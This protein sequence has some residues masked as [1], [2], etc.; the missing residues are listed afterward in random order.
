M[1]VWAPSLPKF[2]S[3]ITAVV[4][5]LIGLSTLEHISSHLLPS[6][7]FE[8]ASTISDPV[9]D[10]VNEENFALNLLEAGEDRSQRTLVICARIL[11]L[12]N[13]KEGTLICRQKYRGKQNLGVIGGSFYALDSLLPGPIH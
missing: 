4:D 5:G 10:L 12:F 3:V 6:T 2:G 1:A 13:G 7:C 11:R 8:K 9:L